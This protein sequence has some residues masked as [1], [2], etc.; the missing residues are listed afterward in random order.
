MHGRLAGAEQG[1]LALLL[2]LLEREFD[3]PRGELARLGEELR[4][5][6]W[7]I[8]RL[9][10]QSQKHQDILNSLESKGNGQEEARRQRMHIANIDRRLN[11]YN[12]ERINYE[13]AVKLLKSSRS[14]HK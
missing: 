10:E 7:E 12:E 4:R 8:H 2:I 1:R 11:G 6:N 5:V 14:R 3:M 13:A 9:K